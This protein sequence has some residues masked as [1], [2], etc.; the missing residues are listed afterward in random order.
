ML[1]PFKQIKSNTGLAKRII[2]P[3]Q[4]Q[5][6]MGYA[7]AVEISGARST[8]YCSGQAAMSPDGI[9][10]AGDMQSQILQSLENIKEVLSAAGYPLSAIVRL[11]FYT[12]SVP[13]F[14]TAYPAAMAWIKKHEISAAC[15]LLGIT[16]L[17]FPQLQVEIEATAVI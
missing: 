8:L 5:D 12:T 17:A 13:D 3:W 16:A 6:A 14:M 2:N 11:S 10:A 4:W 7:Q 15:T 9:P 1:S